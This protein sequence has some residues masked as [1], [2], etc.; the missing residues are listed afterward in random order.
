M[1]EHSS[2]T[3]T[4]AAGRSDHNPKTPVDDSL[5][6]AINQVFTLFRINY[7]NQYYAA[8]NDP[9]Q[10][11]QA[12]RLWLESLSGFSQASILQ[13]AKLLIESS[14]YLP[15]LARMIEACHSAFSEYGLPSARDAYL[16]A[17]NARTPRSAQPWSH[18]AVYFAGRDSNWF[19]LENHSERE[20]WPVFEQHYRK[21]CQRVL[22]GEQL[23]IEAPAAITKQETEMS[24]AQRLEAIK[25]LRKNTGL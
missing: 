4:T 13:G 2:K 22:K 12:K 8:F 9:A 3:S 18:P 1:R 24:Q 5:I 14:E 10:L 20:T 11:N 19:F 23:A 15:S 6:D 21:W 7:H 25:T 16:E 17:C